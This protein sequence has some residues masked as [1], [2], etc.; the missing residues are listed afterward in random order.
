MNAY[1][2]DS[3]LLRVEISDWAS[4]KHQLFWVHTKG[5]NFGENFTN[6]F[7]FKENI[8]QTCFIDKLFGEY[9]HLYQIWDAKSI[10]NDSFLTGTL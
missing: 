2:D 3:N 7:F 8:L 6:I 4:Y 1:D 5:V 9:F 10:Y